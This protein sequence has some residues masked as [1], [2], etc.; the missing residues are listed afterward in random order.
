[1][2][3]ESDAFPV[4]ALD[5]EE[6]ISKPM[7]TDTHRTLAVDDDDDDCSDNEND[8]TTAAEGQT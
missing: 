6:L 1:V 5:D 3:A 8:G 4:D 2:T 7:E